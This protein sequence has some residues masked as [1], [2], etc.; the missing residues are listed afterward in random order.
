MKILQILG[1]RATAEEDRAVAFL[2]ILQVHY[3]V[4]D[5]LANWIAMA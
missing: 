1:S 5:K 2:E 3:T 4:L